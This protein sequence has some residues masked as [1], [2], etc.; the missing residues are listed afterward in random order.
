M[1]IDESLRIEQEEARNAGALGYMARTLAQVTLPHRDQGPELYYQRTNGR[2]TL[3]VRGHKAC[4]LPFG[5]IPRL[6]LAWITTEA[7][8]T[9]S[10]ILELGRSAA[11]FSRKLSLHYNGRDLARLKRQCLAL[12]RS[13]ISIDS[14]DQQGLAFDDIKISA[15]GLVFWNNNEP[16]RKAIWESTLTLSHDFY[17]AATSSPVPID[18]RAYSALKKSPFAMDIYTW[19]TYRMFL[20][21][22]SG[23]AKA[24]I[25]WSSLRL[26][27]GGNY[28]HTAQGLRDFKK[29]FNLRLQEV[30]LFYPAAESHVADAGE[31]LKLTP[32]SLHIRHSKGARLSVIGTS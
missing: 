3:A 10:P 17:V 7:V 2:V 18:L 27:F 9:Q 22:H 32:C 24:L 19:L 4:G 21:R 15:R 31:Y 14:V 12:A 30:L 23:R 5:T 1:L 6:V 16:E 28:A 25:P 8:R 29:A 11:E 20:L 13:V 26:Q